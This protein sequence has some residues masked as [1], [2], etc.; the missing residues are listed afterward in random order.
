MHEP[1]S[2]RAPSL[3]LSLSRTLTRALSNLAG[4]PA[5]CARP[6]PPSHPPQPPQ[7]PPLRALQME[8][9][10]FYVQVVN[11][12]VAVRL[13]PNFAAPWSNDKILEVGEVI[14]ASQRI[15]EQGSGGGGDGGDGGGGDG[16]SG[17]G[18]GGGGG[19]DGGGGGGAVTRQV[20]YR[21]K[22]NSGWAFRATADGEAVLREIAKPYFTFRVRQR[23][24][25]NVRAEPHLDCRCTGQVIAAG[26]AFDE[27]QQKR[28]GEQV[29]YKLADHSGWAFKLSASGDQVIDAVPN[30][31]RRCRAKV[32]IGVRRTPD[33]F[34]GRTEKIIQMGEIFCVSRRIAAD[35]RVQVFYELA[36]GGGWVFRMTPE[37]KQ[38]VE[39]LTPPAPAASGCSIM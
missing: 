5:A 30:A 13:E 1:L 16:G 8:D 18:G 22:D 7:P 38:C 36:D 6:I 37:G 11:R 34:S 12:R 23:F 3:A 33:V 31:P 28:E 32:A 24:R 20:F 29:F 2:P 35:D 4:P 19:G 17:G 14:E 25:I 15:V 39:E 10:P 21:L 9:G 26:E 27:C